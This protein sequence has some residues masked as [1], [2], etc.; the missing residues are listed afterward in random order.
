MYVDDDWYV[1]WRML[2]W[3]RKRSVLMRSFA[4]R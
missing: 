1:R 4:R 2:L 3:R